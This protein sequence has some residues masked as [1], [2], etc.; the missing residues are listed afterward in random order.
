MHKI[1]GKTIWA[2][3]NEEWKQI[4]QQV[5]DER[6]SAAADFMTVVRSLFG[7]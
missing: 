4:E 7:R 1:N 3:T 6:T 2:P 5:R